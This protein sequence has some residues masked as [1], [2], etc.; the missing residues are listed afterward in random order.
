MPRPPRIKIEI[1]NGWVCEREPPDTALAYRPDHDGTMR[2]SRLLFTGVKDQPANPS[3]KQQDS[4]E[5]GVAIRMHQW[6]RTLL[7]QDTATV[8]VVTFT[9]R[10]DLAGIAVALG[11]HADR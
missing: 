5:E 10:V 9:Y 8:I 1:P 4:E 7:W 3:E 2:I 6:Q 11:K